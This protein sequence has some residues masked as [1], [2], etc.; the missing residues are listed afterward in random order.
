MKNPYLYFWL[1][2]LSSFNLQAAI[3]EVSFTGVVY[4]EENAT[5]IGSYDFGYDIGDTIKGQMYVD[6]TKVPDNSAKPEFRDSVAVYNYSG[7]NLENRFVTGNQVNVGGEHTRL[8]SFL[9]FQDSPNLKN[10]TIVDSY[11]FQEAPVQVGDDVYQTSTSSRLALSVTGVNNTADIFS[12]DSFDP[13]QSFSFS[14]DVLDNL[15]R[16]TSGGR[17]TGYISYEMA[18]GV[19][20]VVDSSERENNPERIMASMAFYLTSLSYTPIAVSEPAIGL[21]ALAFI[22]LYS[23]KRRYSEA[24]RS[25][26]L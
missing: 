17:A 10:F 24:K 22:I 26:A 25:N 23:S 9:V 8:Q 2:I 18:T 12:I 21:L 3:I 20:G 13:N 16:D 7:V 5:R 14:K 1:F 4:F 6:L 15:N 11:S 19:N